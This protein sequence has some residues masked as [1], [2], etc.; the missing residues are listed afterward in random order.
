MPIYGPGS[1]S[2][3]VASLVYRTAA[4]TLPASSDGII[5]WDT[6][7]FDP[8]GWHDNVTNKERITPNIAGYFRVGAIW[9]PSVAMTAG[10]RA[11]LAIRKNN[12]DIRGGTAEMPATGV[13]SQPSPSI[14][15]P[16]YL[17]G[18]TDYVTSIAYQTDVA[19]DMDRAVSCF[20]C[21]FIGT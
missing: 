12:V 5:P 14:S 15:V 9:R 17:N 8:F 3:V 10:V 13:S 16:V 2:V 11:I 20:W 7:E 6:E 19:R 18:T 1:S 4:Y 21:E